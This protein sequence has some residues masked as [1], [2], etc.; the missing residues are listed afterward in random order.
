MEFGAVLRWAHLACSLIRSVV[1]VPV[2]LDAPG[3]VVDEVDEGDAEEGQ[4]YGCCAVAVVR[5]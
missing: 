3:E 5:H 2:F 4:D 1:L